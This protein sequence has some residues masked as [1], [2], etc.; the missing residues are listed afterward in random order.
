MADD[1]TSSTMISIAKNFDLEDDLDGRRLDELDE[2]TRDD[3]RR[4]RAQRARRD[5]RTKMSA[6]SITRTRRRIVVIIMIF[7]FLDY[8]SV[9]YSSSSVNSI[10]GDLEMLAKMQDLLELLM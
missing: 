1:W 7:Q 5:D 2:A 4:K 3:G 6:P 8:Y 9:L 10:E